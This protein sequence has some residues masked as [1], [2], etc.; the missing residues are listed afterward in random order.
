M[1]TSSPP[2]Q[3]PPLYGV[4]VV[5]PPGAGKST[6]CAGLARY[7]ELAKRPSA[8]INLD[9]ACEG[10]LTPFSI[11]VRNLCRVETV[12]KDQKLGANGALMY[13]VK[14]LRESPWLCDRLSQL[15]TP[16]AIFDLPGQ[17]ELWTH[18]DDLKEI[19]KTITRYCDAR[20]VVANVVDANHCTRPGTFIANALV[21][22][23]AMLNLE[24]PHINVLSKIDQLPR[25]QASMPFHLNYFADAVDLRRLLPFCRPGDAPGVY[26]HSTEDDD[27]DDDMADEDPEPTGS[28]RLT[29]KICDLVED[30]NLVCFQPLDITDGDSVANLVRMLDK[31]NGHPAGVYEPPASS[32]TPRL[33]FW[34][35]NNHL[36][37]SREPP[38]PMT[39]CPNGL[40]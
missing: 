4:V 7:L 20:L 18:S 29:S 14:V 9:P 5:G 26:D 13:C 3:K 22:L 8:V 19:L 30:F 33:C 27:D 31:A 1:A 21:S 39:A 2:S 15:G 35:P 38:L 28:V 10:S 23:L 37:S 36:S 25:F 40:P 12:M 11:D 6:M 16:Y 17:V 32:T 24:L 34:G